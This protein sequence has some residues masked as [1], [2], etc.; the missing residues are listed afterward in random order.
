MIR[1]N[2]KFIRKLLQLYQ[3]FYIN[4]CCRKI[5]IIEN[6]GFRLVI[7]DIII[8]VKNLIHLREMKLV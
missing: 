2:G 8:H 1:V 5:N 7:L 6:S 3:R 4:G